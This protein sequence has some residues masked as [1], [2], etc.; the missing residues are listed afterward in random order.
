MNGVF[1]Y[2]FNSEL[3]VRISPKKAISKCLLDPSDDICLTGPLASTK[4]PCCVPHKQSINVHLKLFLPSSKEMF[5][6]A[7]LLCIF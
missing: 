3:G 5:L 6:K 4:M 2:G 7:I 1:N